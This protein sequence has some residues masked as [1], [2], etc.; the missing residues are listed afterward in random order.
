MSYSCAENVAQLSRVQR[1]FKHSTGVQEK[2]QKKNSPTKAVR[3]LKLQS[4]QIRRPACSV[5][6]RFKSGKP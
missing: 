2:K 3:G 5:V 6:Y 1:W 4:K